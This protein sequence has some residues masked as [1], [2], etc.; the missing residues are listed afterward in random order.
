MK[1]AY[2][3]LFLFCSI[4]FL[5]SCNKGETY[6][7]L[8]E[9]EH[10]AINRFISEKGIKVIGE[11]QFA[12]QGETTDVNKNEYV[13]LSKSAVYMQ[14]V[15]KGCGSKLEE[16]KQVEILCRF[17][18]YNI[19]KDS[20]MIRND[21]TYKA[22]INGVLYDLSAYP[23]KMS[24]TRVGATITASFVAENSIMYAFHGSAYVPSGWLVPLN[25]INIGRPMKEGDEVAKVRLIVP[26]T[27][28]TPDASSSVYPC[29]YEIT[30][31][32][33]I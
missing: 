8:K 20:M 17:S 22:T 6:S 12:S 30:Y 27:Q 14:I 28:G 2:S 21:I 23:E 18:E 32:R 26:H 1:K 11:E 3:L 9:A 19:K 25:Y 33:D 13:Y 5:T 7:D 31:E 29:F 15:R 10:D 24:V 4:L 16:N